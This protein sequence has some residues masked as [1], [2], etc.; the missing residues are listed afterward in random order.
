MI[1]IRGDLWDQT[2]DILCITTN[3]TVKKNGCGVMG[4]GCAKEA[5]IMFEGIDQTLGENIQRVGNNLSV[6]HRYERT[7]KEGEQFIVS[8]PVKHHWSE[9]ADLKLIEHSAY[10]L[11]TVMDLFP[12]ESAIVPRPGC[13]NGGLDWEMEVKPVL[14]IIWRDYDNIKV[15]TW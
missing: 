1:E 13:G 4:A 12:F 5:K 9:K 7:D 3:G 14:E 8:F 15:I 2:D 11:T 6:L 10:Q